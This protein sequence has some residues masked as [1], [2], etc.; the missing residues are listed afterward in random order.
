VHLKAAA[1]SLKFANHPPA[2]NWLQNCWLCYQASWRK[3]LSMVK[4][5][6]KIN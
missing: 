2:N 4:M 3:R 5:A 1:H 6:S